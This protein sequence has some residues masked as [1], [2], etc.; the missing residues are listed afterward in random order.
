[1]RKKSLSSSLLI[2]I[3]L[4]WSSALSYGAGFWIPEFPSAASSG[5]AMSF[6]AQADDLGALYFNPAGITQLD[7]L[8]IYMNNTLIFYKVEYEHYYSGESTSAKGPAYGPYIALTYDFGLKD[9]NFGLAIY[10]VFGLGFEYPYSGAQRYL[11]QEVD[12]MAPTFNPTMSFKAT[13][14]LSVGL[15]LKVSK[16]EIELNKAIDTGYGIR[17]YDIDTSLNGSA[18]GY[19]Y[20]I[21]F[22]YEVSESL[23]F[24]LVY[25]SRIKF[26][27]D[28]VNLDVTYPAILPYED[29]T[30]NGETEIILP[31]SLRAGVFFKPSPKIALNIDINWMNWKEWDELI[32]HIDEP[33]VPGYPQEIVLK[34]YWNNS[35]AYRLGGEYTFSEDLLFRAGIAYDTTAIDDEWLEPGVPDK[36]KLNFAL[37][38]GYRINNFKVD[39]SILYFITSTREIRNSEQM[40]PADGNY[41]SD[42]TFFCLGLGYSF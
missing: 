22:L 5:M 40:P 26:K 29:K 36:N 14:K 11:V 28:N 24:G 17:D 38:I 41:D 21:S 12:L 7:G 2:M 3:A 4:I 8:N 34:R 42:F 35:F 13:D 30:I 15:G 10:S 20:D 37:G 33:V 31:A 9:I 16:L 27:A 23:R 6:T 1:M 19:G 39:L 25:D 32:V 18:Y